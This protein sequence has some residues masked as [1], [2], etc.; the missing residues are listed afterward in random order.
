MGIEEILGN[1]REEIR[2][3]AKK[4]GVTSMRVYGPIAR[5]EAGMETDVDLLIENGPNTTPWFPGGFVADMEALLGRPV[6]VAWEDSLPPYA[7]HIAE[8]AVPL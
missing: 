1:K 8:E 4:H 3:I 2:R 7:R 6:H 5:G